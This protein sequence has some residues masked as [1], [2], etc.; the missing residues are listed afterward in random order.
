MYRLMTTAEMH[1]VLHLSATLRLVVDGGCSVRSWS[2]WSF[3]V[4]RF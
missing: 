4:W 2:L 3:H 1:D